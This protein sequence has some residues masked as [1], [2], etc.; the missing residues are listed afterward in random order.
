LTPNISEPTNCS[1]NGWPA[2]WLVREIRWYRAP[3][4]RRWRETKVWSFNEDLRH[5]YPGRLTV[6]II[7]GLALL[8]AIG[9]LFER[10]RRRRRHLGQQTTRDWLGF[11]TVVGIALA[12]GLKAV[13]DY[14]IERTA[15]NTVAPGFDSILRGSYHAQRKVYLS[16]GGPIGLR[17]LF[18]RRWFERTVQ[19]DI[20]AKHVEH[21][22][23]FPHLR[24]LR[25]QQARLGDRQWLVLG[26][27]KQL[28]LL[29]LEGVKPASPPGKHNDESN[30]DQ[31]LAQLLD[32]L[33]GLTR[34]EVLRLDH[35][36]FGDQSARALSANQN[37]RVLVVNSATAL[38]NEGLAALAQCKNLEVLDLQVG[39]GITSA[40]V[41]LVKQLP[42]LR[43]LKLD[44]ATIP[45]STH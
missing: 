15:L 44:G 45:E 35:C 16:S 14:R 6:N 42:R 4:I 38:T 5:F 9:L 22:A 11:I 17:D 8:A 39:Q 10:W 21:L 13:R 12:V 3:T 25:V 43:I 37:L 30:D 33:E 2:T 40:G 41:Q 31:S 32:H 27:L 34:L 28:E 20:P 24:V 36:A 23:S 19:L 18:G 26:G 29:W 7:V 1:F